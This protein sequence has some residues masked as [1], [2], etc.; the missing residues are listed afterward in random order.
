MKRFFLFMFCLVSQISLVQAFD[1]QGRVA[2][3]YPQDNR[4][5]E[6]YSDQGFPE[7][8]IE[9]SQALSSTCQCDQDLDG[10]INLSFYQ[11]NGHSTC[12][13]NH[14]SVTNWD[15][16]FG[17]KKS[18]TLFEMFKPYLGFGV[19]VAYV[20]FHDRSHYVKS[21][22]SSYGPSILA[23]SGVKYDLSCNLFLDMFLDYSYQWFNFNSKK[24]SVAVRNVNA[25]GLK[26]GLGL[27]YKF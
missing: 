13:H 6:V 21:H 18:F 8:E 16:N 9:V 24:R 5:R 14:S 10:F 26:L 25:G 7:Y 17:V 27:G 11:K 1:I 19:G 4:I 22:V 12:L 15:L 3:F 2:Y 23:K 20:R